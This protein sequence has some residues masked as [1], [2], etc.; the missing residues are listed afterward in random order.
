VSIQVQQTDENE[1]V[2]VDQSDDEFEEYEWAGQTRVRACSMMARDPQLAGI[3][4]FLRYVLM[5][6]VEIEFSDAVVIN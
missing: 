5:R 4:I 2:D 3:C 6:N 1:D